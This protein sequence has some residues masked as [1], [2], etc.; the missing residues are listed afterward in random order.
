MHKNISEC[1]IQIKILATIFYDRVKL[2]DRF[3]DESFEDKICL[4]IPV[5]LCPLCAANV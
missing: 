3:V 4:D 5:S 1:E 2:G